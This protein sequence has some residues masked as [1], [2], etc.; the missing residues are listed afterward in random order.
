MTGDR[1]ELS[2]RRLLLSAAMAGLAGCPSGGPV[3]GTTTTETREA[4]DGGRPT[5]TGLAV[6][7]APQAAVDGAHAPGPPVFTSIGET[8]RAPE[9][10]GVESN[11]APWNPDREGAYAWSVVDA[12]GGSEATVGDGA[13]VEFEPDEP[14][15]YE[16]ELDAPDGT[17]PLTVR[18]F[19][20]QTAGEPR[21]T[22]TLSGDGEADTDGILL[23]ADARAPASS[24][25][26]DDD[27]TVEFL[28]DD[29]DRDAFSGSLAVEGHEARLSPGDLSGPV[30]V[31]AAAAGRTGRSVA[32]TVR[33]DPDGTVARPTEPP[34]WAED[35]VVYEIF[36]R[37][38][39]ADVDFE[40][41]ESKVEYVDSMGAD[42][43]WLTPILDAHSHRDETQPGGPHGY[44]VV[45]YFETA[46]ALGTREAF[47]SFVD[48]CHERDIE[49][50]FDLVVNH[51]AREHP[52]FQSAT[53]GED[54][55]FRDWY[56]WEGE[57]ARY[58]FGWRGIPLLDFDE[59]AVRSWV[60]AVAEE[61]AEVVDGFR[62][63][64]A[65][66]VPHSFWKEF[67]ARIKR[68]HPDFLLLGECVPW[69]DDYADFAENEFGLHYAEGLFETLGAIGAGEEPAEALHDV[70]AW[71]RDAGYP[72][73][74]GLLNYVEN[75]DTDRYLAGA[76]RRA[77]MAAGAATFTLPGAPMV[78]YGQETGL[79]GMRERMN[80]D[81]ADEALRA[82]YRNLADVRH[83]EPALQS[84]A[85]VVPL[86]VTPGNDRVT[87]YAREADGRRVH[88]LL[89]FGEDPVEVAQHPAVSR[90]DRIAGADV[91]TDDGAV[92]VDAA[93]VLRADAL[94]GRGAPLA[95]FSD[96]T[97]DATAPDGTQAS[98][99]DLRA[100]DVYESDDAHQFVWS[101]ENLPGDG[102]S[103][104]LQL[105]LRDPDADGGTTAT[106]TG[107]DASLADPAQ[108]RVVVTPQTAVLEAS[109]GE[110]VT[111]LDA[112][113]VGDQIRVD[114]PNEYLPEDPR[115]LR[116]TALVAGYDPDAPGDV[117]Q[118]SESNV[119]DLLVGPSTDEAAVRSDAGATLPSVSLSTGVQ[120][121]L[122]GAD[123]VAAWDDPTGDDHGPGTYTYPDS[124]RWPDGALDLTRFAVFEGEERYRVQFAFRGPVE[125]D[126]PGSRPQHLQLYLRYPEESGGATAAREG[127]G[128]TLAAPYHS[129]VVASETTTAVERP[130]GTVV[131]DDVT[132][133]T[134]DGVRGLWLSI[135]KATVGDLSTTE[136]VPLVLGN[137][138]T[139]DGGV[140]RVERERDVRDFGGRESESQSNVLDLLTPDGVRQSEVL[141]ADGEPPSIPLLEFESGT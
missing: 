54:A 53:A 14:G 13:A 19:P 74:V 89:N 75:H 77:Q 129:R 67:R 11:L 113:V 73:H 9:F 115:D 59:P 84:D 78:Y 124:S 91:G 135:P 21:P 133:D 18:A 131:T 103:Q 16:L 62:C 65:W 106:R 37:R 85:D 43:V 12:P 23:R 30:R 39:G 27:L 105:Y 92:T 109:D 1:T 127:V 48:A 58:Y 116:F 72:D 76:T 36:V 132:V 110:A 118:T 29:R 136:L 114:V 3:E 134:I 5:D 32:D 101:F 82:F 139:G 90:T 112:R 140:A 51:T 97:G 123:L 64:V 60:L 119:A 52:Y 93:V 86:S 56:R 68:Q 47:Q 94:S 87:G 31:H 15:T 120:N 95:T 17:H 50:I 99:L 20:R 34:A 128:A 10:A 46:D 26:S 28:V 122:L 6:A 80:W 55:P 70:A 117:A 138:L 126:G 79:T 41:L 130:D 22:L 83:E 81:D 125:T 108:Y 35:A 71:R 57:E 104:H 38:F 2:R 121:R 4:T 141:A 111:D 44:D 96:P 88:V 107:I 8:V 42:A 100:L 25:E 137:S 49:V 66:G 63:D 7:D 33:V 40:F 98:A 61:W 45:D 69:E 24:D 102:A